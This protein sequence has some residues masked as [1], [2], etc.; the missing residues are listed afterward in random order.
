MEAWKG[1]RKSTQWKCRLDKN[2]IKVTK[3]FSWWHNKLMCETVTHSQLWFLLLLKFHIV[4]KQHIHFSM[5]SFI[6]FFSSISFY[7]RYYFLSLI[8]VT[9]IEGADICL[10]SLSWI[11]LFWFCYIDD[12]FSG[13]LF[14]ALKRKLK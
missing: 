3:W 9:H 1:P 5:Y 13:L 12:L 2:N 4:K 6:F 11:I 8:F 10:H 7:R 14:T